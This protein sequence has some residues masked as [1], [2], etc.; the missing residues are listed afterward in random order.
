[1]IT[2]HQRM[3]DLHGLRVF[4]RSMCPAPD[5]TFVLGAGFPI[6]GNLR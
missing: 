5:E 2:A 4:E 3:L 6:E 1:M